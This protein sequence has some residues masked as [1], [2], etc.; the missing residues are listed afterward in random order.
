MPDSTPSL[1]DWL[2]RSKADYLRAVD[3]GQGGEWTIVMGN[4]AG[5]LDSIASSIAFAWFL[6]TVR[7]TSAVPMIQT[8]CAD[9]KLRPEN[10]YALSLAE[11]DPSGHTLLC[12]DD[13]P[14]SSPFPS[15]NFALV[16]HNRLLSRFSENNSSAR[17]VAVVDHHDD[18]GLYKDT[19]DPRLIAVP[20][21]SCASL[22]SQLLARSCA[23]A[24]PAELAT[25][26]LCGI[27]ID[28]QGLKKGGKA[29]PTD[30][31]AAGFLLP[32]STLGR[33]L[34]V[35]HTEPNDVPAVKELTDSLQQKKS[36]VSDLGA[37]D[38]LRRDYKE[39]SWKP[40][41][42]SNSSALP[43]GLATVPL[44]LAEWAHRADFWPAIESW[45]DERDLAALGILTSYHDTKNKKHTANGHTKGKGKHKREV[46]FVLRE[47]GH[48]Q[49]PRAM[50]AGLEGSEALQ[51]KE[52]KWEKIGTA[53]N[54]GAK[55]CAR[56]WKQRNTDATRKQIAPLVKTI[57]EGTGVSRM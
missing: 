36:A 20:T 15:S 27:L 19:A 53:P 30:R 54:L 12:M 31:D 24:I 56:V 39:Y 33:S 4:E 44:G 34:Q 51:L 37:R 22:V 2:A 50:W 7:G 21:G 23:D 1:A 16:D 8:S 25:L 38:L 26:L 42:T 5:D 47:D 40:S 43:V 18:E 3:N 45:M 52:R 17:V 57:I 41:W 9:L 28:T 6:N 49:L 10:I 55:A 29:E 14:S 35:T 48:G 13:I 11:I 46:M 32:R